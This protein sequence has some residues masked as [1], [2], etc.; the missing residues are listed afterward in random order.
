MWS[1][2]DKQVIDKLFIMD[3]Y[4]PYL[5]QDY[6]RRWREVGKHTKWSQASIKVDA[7]KKVVHCIAGE[8][9]LSCKNLLECG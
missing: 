1:N 4:I 8:C 2:G 7:G 6:C 5:V 9:T 3:I